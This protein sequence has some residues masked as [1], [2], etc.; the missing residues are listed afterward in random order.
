MEKFV[1]LSLLEKTYT[2]DTPEKLKK[3]TFAKETNQSL[4]FPNKQ[5]ALNNIYVFFTKVTIKLQRVKTLQ[6]H[7]A[8]NQVV[9]SKSGC[10]HDS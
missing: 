1:M 5:A 8:L 3:T 9:T 10:G 7:K 4:L 2:I 6:P